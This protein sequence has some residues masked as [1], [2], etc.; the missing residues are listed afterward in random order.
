MLNVW[1][2]SMACIKVLPP[3]ITALALSACASEAPHPTIVALHKKCADTAT[4][5]DGYRDCMQLGLERARLV[6]HRHNES[7]TDGSV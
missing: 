3:V 7:D 2:V 6:R 4:P 1:E 5:G